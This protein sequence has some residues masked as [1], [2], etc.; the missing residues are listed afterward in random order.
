MLAFRLFRLQTTFGSWHKGV[1]PMS[2]LRTNMGN[3]YSDIIIAACHAA[4][5]IQMG[6]HMLNNVY[7]FTDLQSQIRG[8]L[9]R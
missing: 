8:V 3:G 9:K 5:A 2:S 1:L 4:R 7:G 6:A